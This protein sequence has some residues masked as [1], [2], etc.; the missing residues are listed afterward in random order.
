MDPS[1]QSICISLLLTFVLCGAARSA[2]QCNSRAEGPPCEFA[3]VKKGQE[4]PESQPQE[5]GSAGWLLRNL[6]PVPLAN[7]LAPQIERWRVKIG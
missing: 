3:V 6:E 4:R 7:F 2:A 1:V 5:H